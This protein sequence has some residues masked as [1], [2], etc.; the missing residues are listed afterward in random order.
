MARD[1]LIS[2]VVV[3]AVNLMPA[4][5][6]PTWAVLA[7]LKLNLDVPAVPLVLVGATCA[8][9]GRYTLAR[10]S[11][12]ER[13]R[14]PAERRESLET[15]GTRLESEPATAAGLLGVFLVSPLPSAQLFIAAG[16]SNVRLGRLTLVFLLGR[17]VTY[18]IYVTGTVVAVDRFGDVL[19]RGLVSPW[20]IA[21]QLL[22]IAGLVVL[23]KIDWPAVLA[24]IDARRRERAQR[25][26]RRSAR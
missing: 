26:T 3:F 18:S 22:M 19:R 16:L 13:R 15:L 10:V 17:L 9:A 1:L 4:F 5:G 20:G 25:R 21:I 23:V 14:L 24:R 7:F 11:R 8:A 2:A 6:P 12:R